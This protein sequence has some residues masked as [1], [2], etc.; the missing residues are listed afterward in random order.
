MNY[1]DGYVQICVA[2]CK[3]NK[4]NSKTLPLICP[5]TNMP[6]F[7]IKPDYLIPKISEE[8]ICF[9]ESFN[10][11]NKKDK[12]RLPIE[13]KYIDKNFIDTRCEAFDDLAS[14]GNKTIYT[15][16]TY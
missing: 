2:C 15:M 14:K 9:A 16:E 11:T 7:A 8:L 13:C 5:K 10:I 3:L 12:T 4:E 1:K 6:C